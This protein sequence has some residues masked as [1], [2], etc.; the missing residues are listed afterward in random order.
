MRR[1]LFTTFNCQK[2][3]YTEYAFVHIIMQR[4]IF[5]LMNEETVLI[6]YS[7]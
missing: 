5:Q 4:P 2:N 1:L 7:G 3:T 6:L